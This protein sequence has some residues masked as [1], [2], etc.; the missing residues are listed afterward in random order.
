MNDKVLAGPLELIII[1][2][3]INILLLY[4]IN[5]KNSYDNNTLKIK[6]KSPVFSLG[7]KDEDITRFHTYMHTPGP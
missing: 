6:N 4:Y 2:Y 7:S 5:Y 3:F 1:I